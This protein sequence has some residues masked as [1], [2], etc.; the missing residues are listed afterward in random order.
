MAFAIEEIPD[1]D[2]LFRRIHHTHLLPEG[3]VSS[4]AFKQPRMSVNWDKYSDAQRTADENSA[5]VVALMAGGC[6]ELNQT[7]EHMPISSEQPDGPNQAHA[8]V[9]G[10]KTGA[11][12]RKLRDIAKKVWVR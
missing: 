8:E 4:A 3:E 5:A 6:R 2:K 1:E 11:I 12:C 7:V 10:N 9:C